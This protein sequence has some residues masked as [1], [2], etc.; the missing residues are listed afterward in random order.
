MD[1]QYSDLISIYAMSTWGVIKDF[2]FSTH[3]IRYISKDRVVI[4]SNTPFYAMQ[5][6]YNSTSSFSIS[7]VL[8]IYQ[9]RFSDH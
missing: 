1:E 9:E 6:S 8:T 3:T 2:Y 7:S 4:L 5:T